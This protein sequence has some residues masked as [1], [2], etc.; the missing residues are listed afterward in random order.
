MRAKSTNTLAVEAA[1]QRGAIC[2]RDLV[3]ATGLDTAAARAVLGNLVRSEA[4][5]YEMRFV[6][7]ALRP[8]AFYTLVGTAAVPAQP[9]TVDWVAALANAMR[10]SAVA[11]SDAVAA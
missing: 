7:W 5:T 2:L 3:K 8:V 10:P 11:Y 9:A 6:P 1:L 4:V